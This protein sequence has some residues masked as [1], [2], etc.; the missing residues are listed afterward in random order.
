MEFH[1]LWIIGA[2]LF[3]G[4]WVVDV[5]FVDHGREKPARS[6]YAVPVIGAVMCLMFVCIQIAQT[7]S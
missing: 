7:L 4:W 6:W 1:F 3:L 5:F 2:P